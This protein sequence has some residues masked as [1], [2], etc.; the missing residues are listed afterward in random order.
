MNKTILVLVFIALFAGGVFAAD[1]EADSKIAQV[2]IYS[3]NALVTRVAKVRLIPGEHKVIFP[4]I[5]P[6]IDSNSLRVKGEGSAEVKIL[7]A[8][9]ENEI[10]QDNPVEKIKNIQ[11]KIL[12]LE[13]ENRKLSNSRQVQIEEKAFLDSVRLFS[14]QQI[15]KDLITKVPSVQDLENTLKFLDAR[16]KENY[17]QVLDLELLMRE[18]Q[19]KMD[20]LRRELAQISGPVN[21]L[22]RSIVVELEVVKPGELNLDVS[23]LV[24]GASWQPIYDARAD[25]DKSE[26]E[27]ISHC[28]VQQSTGE[29]WQDVEVYLS[30][31]MINLSGRMPEVAPWFIRPYQP[32]PFISMKESIG[33]SRGFKKVDSSKYQSFD[34]AVERD[35]LAEAVPIK[36]ENQYA[37]AQDKGVSVVYKLMRKAEIKSDNAEHKLPVSSQVLKANFEYSAYPRLSANAYLGSKVINSPQ[38]QLLAG[39]VN[40]FLDGDYVGS[41]DIDNVA[42]TEEFDLYLGLDE[43][44][45]VKRELLEKKVDDILIGGIPAPNRK[46]IYKY[47]ITLE[48]YKNKKSKI[49]VFESMPVSQDDK[50][51]IK[52]DKVS[53]EPK[54]KD[55][56]DKK[57]VWHWELELNPKAKQ[58]I[59]YNYIVECPR[60]MQLEGID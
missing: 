20:V 4:N 9:V 10:L 6:E 44:I 19:K 49:N 30:T 38:L 7:G 36:A 54:E 18:N 41:S 51:R 13:D 31:A 24:S 1:I 16:L 8:Q 28:N 40:I 29:D 3:G 34:L 58:E 55:W 21:K 53:L 43:S 46:V 50:I 48:N 14:N 12:N 17:S 15:P 35:G 37:Q 5:I 23:Y 60:D 59:F 22:K 32:R 56:K 45:K 42:P 52:M 2:V 11:D 57:G 39:R 25:F 27:L 47:K 26:V 33:S